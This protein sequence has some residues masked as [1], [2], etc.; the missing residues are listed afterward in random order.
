MRATALVVS[1]A[2]LTPLAACSNGSGGGDEGMVPPVVA[3]CGQAKLFERPVDP[4]AAGPWAVG[5]KTVQLPDILPDGALQTV[6]VWYPAKPG[7]DAG[8]P[9]VVYDL[10]EWLPPTEA[11]KIPD[12]ENPPQPCDCVRD[13]PIDEKRGPY[14]VVIF[15]HGTA[16]FRTQSLTQMVHW[17]KR[18]FVVLSADHPGIGL[19]DIIGNT[20]D[21]GNQTRNTNRLV[22]AIQAPSGPLAFLAGRIDTAHVGLSGHSAGGGAIAQ[23]DDTAG[24][25]VRMP[26]AA[27]GTTAGPSL[28]STLVM[29]GKDDMVA[30]YDRVKQGYTNSPTKKRLVGIANAGHLAFSDLCYIGRDQGG[31]LAIAKRNG[32]NVLDLV[33]R[34]AQDGCMAG[35]LPAERGWVVVNHATTAVLEETLTCST[36]ATAQAAATATLADVAEYAEALQ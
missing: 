25:L 17:A 13:L 34:L 35:Q 18:G 24:V 6:E 14:P 9:K 11:A 26:L 2:V 16:A 4:A 20:F 7:S 28:V 32:V 30:T 12:A 22:A 8:K 31:I 27:G 15:V 19:K 36:T 29:G 5:V 1:L 21:F 33:A 3:A 23:V 10:R